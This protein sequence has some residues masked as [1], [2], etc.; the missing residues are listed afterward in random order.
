MISTFERSIN[1]EEVVGKQYLGLDAV[2]DVVRWYPHQSGGDG[3]DGALQVD[4]LVHTHG[5]ITRKVYAPKVHRVQESRR[6]PL[7]ASIGI[8]NEGE[9]AE[10][11]MME[12]EANLV[13]VL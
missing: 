7:L 12:K 10:T 11:A 5:Y 8:G 6:Q 3:L 4:W 13:C 1:G 2:D 9:F